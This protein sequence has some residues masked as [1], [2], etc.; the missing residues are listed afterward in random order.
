MA[1]KYGSSTKKYRNA[2]LPCKERERLEA[3][4]QEA[5]RQRYVLETGLGEEGAPFKSTDRREAKNQCEVASTDASHILDE[6]FAHERKHGCVG[7]S[8]A[9]P[10]PRLNVD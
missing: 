2:K 3:A 9:D 6:L 7:R 1:H 8:L 5:L 10:L 4:Y